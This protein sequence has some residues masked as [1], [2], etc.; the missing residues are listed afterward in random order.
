MIVGLFLPPVQA[1]RNTML[2]EP[3]L[4]QDAISFTVTFMDMFTFHFIFIHSQKIWG[5][6]LLVST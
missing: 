6:G 3:S 4:E 1:S 2:R 5:W